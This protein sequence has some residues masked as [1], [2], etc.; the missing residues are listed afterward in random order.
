MVEM[1]FSEDPELQ[2][3]T[4]QKFRKLLSKGNPPLTRVAHGA[5]PPCSITTSHASCCMGSSTSE[6]NPPIDEVINTPG[7][8]ERFV[9]FLKLSVNCTLQV[10]SLTLTHAHLHT[11]THRHTH[12][13]THTLACKYTRTY[14]HT[15]LQVHTDTD[16]CTQTFTHTRTITRTHRHSHP[17]TGTHGTSAKV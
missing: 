14:I 2:L 3:S 10:H 6:P 4:T 15:H 7:L 16:R 12:T 17:H 9:E 5:E 11:S 1:L 8:V 13:L